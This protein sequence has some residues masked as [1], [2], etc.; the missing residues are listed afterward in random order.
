MGKYTADIFTV[1][2]GEECP[3]C[4]MHLALLLHF[5]KYSLKKRFKNHLKTQ[6][7]PLT[8]ELHSLANL[9]VNEQE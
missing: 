1:Y 4:G 9:G 2:Q 7:V 6:I 8:L 5:P 3:T